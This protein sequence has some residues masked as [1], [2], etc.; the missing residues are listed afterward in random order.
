M[1]KLGSLAEIDA[2]VNARPVREAFR[3]RLQ[4]LENAEIGKMLA[5]QT[6]QLSRLREEAARLKTELAASKEALWRSVELVH[7]TLRGTL[8]K[9]D[10]RSFS[11]SRPS[12]DLLAFDSKK[13]VN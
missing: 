9:E 13:K 12:A 11:S 4:R 8:V 2:W 7:K 3:L 1:L 10:P 5:L 6:A